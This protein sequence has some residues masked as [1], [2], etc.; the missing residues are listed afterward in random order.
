VINENQLIDAFHIFWAEST[1]A[2]YF[3]TC[4][5]KL[6]RLLENH[7]KYPPTV[8]VVLPSKLMEELKKRKIIN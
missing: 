4:D 1:N 6:I 8:K 3:L 5:R 2:D 7:K